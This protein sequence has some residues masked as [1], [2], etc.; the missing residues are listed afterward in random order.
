VLP[1]LSQAQPRPILGGF[2]ENFNP[3]PEDPFIH[4]L[5]PAFGFEMS[6]ITDFRGVVEATGIQGKAGGESRAASQCAK[7][8]HVS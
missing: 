3:V 5:P 6:T 7:N 2:D 8:P 1:H 4:L